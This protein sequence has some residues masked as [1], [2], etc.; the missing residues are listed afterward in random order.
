MNKLTVGICSL[1]ALGGLVSCSDDASTPAAGSGSL[2]LSLSA[3]NRVYTGTRADDSRVSVVPEASEFKIRMEKNDGSF[4]QEWANLTAFNRESHF[5]IGTYTLSATYGDP[6]KE[7]FELPSYEASTEVTIESGVESH[8][9]LTATLTNAMVSVRYTDDFKSLFT[10]YSAAV[11][12]TSGADYVVM[13]Q[14]EDRPAFMRPE[15]LSIRLTL[16]NGQGQQVTVSP[17]NFTAEARHHYIVTMGVKDHQGMGEARLDVE[18]TEVVEEEFVDIPLGDELFTAPAPT[19]KAVDFPSSMSYED[20][21]GFTPEGD[22]R[23]NVLA[24]GGLRAVNVNVNSARPLIF[25]NSV[26]LVNAD[27]VTQAN[28]AAS[29]LVAEGFYRNPDKAGVINFKEFFGNLPEG[30]YR[31]HVD[32]EDSATRV[33]ELPV[34]FTVTVKG[35]HISIEVAEHPKYMGKEMTVKVTAN[36]ADVKSRIRFEVT[37]TNEEWV[38]AG[39]VEVKNAARTRADQEYSFLYTLSIPEAEHHDVKVRAYYGAETNPKC[40]LT[41]E[42]VEFPVYTL[43][44]DAHASKCYIKVKPANAED[45]PILMDNLKFI[46]DGA[47]RNLSKSA[48]EG[49]FELS[50]LT[51]GKSYG[52]FSTY[53]S[54]P[55]NPHISGPSFTTESTADLSNGQFSESEQTINIS[56]VQV[57]GEW[58]VGLINYTT[59]SSIQRNTPTGWATIND[60]TCWTGASNKNTWFIVPSTF[61]ENEKAVIRSVGYNHAGTTPGRS[62]DNFTYYC[63]NT[64]SDADLVK[65]SGELF[66]GSYSYDGAEHRVDG[67]SWSTRPE[68]VS[69]MYT[70]APVNGEQA[71]AIVKVYAGDTEISSG[72]VLLS[73]ADS[74]QSAS[75]NLSAYP[76]GKKATRLSICFRSTRSGVTPAVNIPHGSDLREGVSLTNTNKGANDYKAVATGSQ[77]VIDDV[78]L[79]Y[80]SS[81]THAAARRKNAKAGRKSNSKR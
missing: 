38:K 66:L 47:E 72:S 49:V 25:G 51:P 16:T 46:I 11:K 57:G 24:Y 75:V 4:S 34:E 28:V 30:T 32:V 7:G 60:L 8:E 64:P 39:I 74:E 40:E 55:D 37:D 6:T 19:V 14:T 48:E 21:E 33:C 62:A 78:R 54:Y 45:L 17:Y 43:E 71:E 44:T 73:A 77:L 67:I 13:S 76:F 80:D 27:A 9:E 23:V 68:S 81:A 58:R 20:F 63:T 61:T 12:S 59:H 79:V 36:K 10:A 41:D 1:I 22:P 70:Y 35:V 2:K 52:E 50:G 29:G 42:G 3:D 31:V 65:A 56:N 26:Q 53:L 5:A 15:K 69:F 18:V